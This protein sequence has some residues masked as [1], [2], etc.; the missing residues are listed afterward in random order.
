MTKNAARKLLIVEDDIGLQAQLKWAYDDWAVTIVG[1]RQAAVDALR[2]ERPAVVTLDLGLPPDPDGTSEGFAALEA[3][4]QLAPQTKVIVAS[5][6]ELHESAQTAIR[7][8]AYDFYR[9]P[10]DID[11]LKLIVERAFALHRLEEENRKLA[12]Q[13]MQSRQ[14]LGRIITA[15]PEMMKV[16]RT[17]ERVANTRASVMLLGA[18]GTGKEL[19]ARGLH[20]ESDRASRPF[21][22]INCAAIPENLLESELF[23]LGEGADTTTS[24]STAGRIEQADG[25]TL[26]LDEI[27]D[28]S[29][30]LQ[31]KLLRF[32]QERMIKQERG[33]QTLAIDT[34]IVCATHHNIDAMVGDGR[35][36]EDL[37]YRLAEI[38]VRI[39][40]LAD[41][42][43]DTILLAK[44][45]LVR[46]SAEMN[47]RITGFT[48]DALAT[49]DGWRW[50]GNVRE[51]ENRIRRAV[52]MAEGRQITTEDLDM[53]DT[54]ETPYPLSLKAAR[55]EVDRHIIRKVFA[56]TDGNISEAAKTL[57]ISRPT[58]YDLMRQYDLQA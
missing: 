50:P 15:A 49:L 27:G 46:F 44:A 28:M 11:E 42:T 23:G 57:G 52:I 26:F 54:A 2:A 31:A 53:T 48:A 32:L 30:A 36:R 4:M 12:L 56:R 1:T 9:K 14:V 29:L 39:P 34:R 18:S 16:A 43:G 22:A 17:I 55:E 41:R 38:A 7:L 37:F 24:G 10:I 25:G 51:L 58:L 5:G 35:F 21:V 19:L 47:P 20:E 13:V 8:G 40:P 45:F 3:I 6:H 33:W